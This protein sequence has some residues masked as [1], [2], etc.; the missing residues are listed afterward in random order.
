MKSNGSFLWSMAK[1]DFWHQLKWWAKPFGAVLIIMLLP[2][3]GIITLAC[4]A[5]KDDT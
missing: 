3:I 1:H 5:R 2:T 4:F